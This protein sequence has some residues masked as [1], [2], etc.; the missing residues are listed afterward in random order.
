MNLAQCIAPEWA[1]EHCKPR[2]AMPSPGSTP[3]LRIVTRSADG[4]EVVR[5]RHGE[6]IE[7]DAFEPAPAKRESMPPRMAKE[8]PPKRLRKAHGVWPGGRGRAGF[9]LLKILGAQGRSLSV[10]DLREAAGVT[11]SPVNETCALLRRLAWR[12]LVRRSGTPKRYHYQI[13]T[14][15]LQVLAE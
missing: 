13:T 12:K 15:G 14:L 2:H 8:P 7:P 3:V 4:I 9:G 6:F 10:G 1:Q 11:S 5:R